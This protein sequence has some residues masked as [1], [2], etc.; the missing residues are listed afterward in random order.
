MFLD[1]L[2][3]LVQDYQRTIAPLATNSWEEIEEDKLLSMFSS[4]F[5]E[6]TRLGYTQLVLMTKLQLF[7]EL[8]LKQGENKVKKLI[9][10][11]KKNN[12]ITQEGV[13]K[14]YTLTVKDH[15]LV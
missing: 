6:K 4:V 13:K 2:P 8:Q 7:N 1:G 3:T 10:H 14:P 11:A 9:T 5:H 12:W 15:G